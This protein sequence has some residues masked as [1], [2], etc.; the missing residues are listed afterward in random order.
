MRQ[1]SLGCHLADIHNIY[2]QAVV[3][4]QLLKE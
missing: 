1:S 3:E 2:Q 4:E